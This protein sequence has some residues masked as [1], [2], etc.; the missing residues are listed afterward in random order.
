MN[1]N[2]ASEDELAVLPDLSYTQARALIERRPFRSWDEVRLIPGFGDR[3][4]D[5]LKRRGVKLGV[6]E[7]E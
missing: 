7:E 6:D 4:V 2:T 5:D 1:L 3:I